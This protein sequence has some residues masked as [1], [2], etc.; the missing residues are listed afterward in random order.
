MRH[1]ILDTNIIIRNPAILAKGNEQVRFVIP[2][3]VILEL[4]RFKYSRESGERLLDLVENALQHGAYRLSA[5]PN[6]ILTSPTPENTPRYRLS[7][8]DFTIAKSAEYYQKQIYPKD[9][10]PETINNTF[11]VTDD[12][13]LAQYVKFLGVKT[14]GSRELET[15]LRNSAITNQDIKRKAS[16]ITSLQHKELKIGIILGILVSVIANLIVTNFYAIFTSINI[17]G[18]I[19]LIPSAGILLYWFRSKNRLAYGIAEFFFGLITG[20]RIF[21]PNFDYS[22][23]NTTGFI[24]IAGSLYIMVRGMDNIGKSII[25]TRFEVIWKR[26]FSES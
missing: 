4:A 17:W 3:P 20:L 21:V 7:D 8:A 22:Q 5:P 14:I 15:E 26:Y 13:F 9:L 1:F 19:V 10:F 18:T 23:L 2:E 6:E 12:K 25:G 11:F 24:Q 16:F